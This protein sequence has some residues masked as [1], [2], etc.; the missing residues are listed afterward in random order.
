MAVKS[1][2][3]FLSRAA[4]P[5]GEMLHIGCGRQRLEGWV[6]IDIQELPEVDVVA[7]VT[8]GLHFRQARAIF[9]EHFLEHL[10][11]DEALG[12]LAS[13]HR[14]L[15][16]EGWLRLS[17]PN[18]DWVW[19]THY[20]TGVP[21]EA[22]RLQGLHLNRAFY[23]WG[24]RFL[25]NRALL[26]EA[27]RACGFEGLRWCSWGESTLPFLRGIERHEV[28]R[29]TPE[30]PHVLIAEARPGPPN[31]TLLAAFRELAEDEFLAHAR[32]R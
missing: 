20:E 6:N 10:A 15:A 27:L 11:L 1:F 22:Q 13:A 21:V 9:A 2:G 8:R 4:P 24:H 32:V 28:S 3:R 18:L 26:G 23:G 12:F 14:A 29:D 16:A 17:T 7:D 25:W 19:Q 5:T 31:P 30:L